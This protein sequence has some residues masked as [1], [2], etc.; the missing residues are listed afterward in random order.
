MLVYYRRHYFVQRCSVTFS[1]TGQVLWPVD[2][3]DLSSQVRSRISELRSPSGENYTLVDVASTGPLLRQ[4]SA[5]VIYLNDVV[6]RRNISSLLEALRAS[7]TA[8][9]QGI[10]YCIY[11]FNF[12]DQENYNLLFLPPLLVTAE[13]EMV[14]K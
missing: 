14:Y 4:R 5:L 3:P 2:L 7:L 11:I 6:S 1:T 13:E 9:S 10:Y 8:L 12:V